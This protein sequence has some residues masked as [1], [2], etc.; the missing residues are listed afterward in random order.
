MNVGQVAAAAGISVRTLHHWDAVGLLT[1]GDRTS[2]GYRSY[3]EADLQRLQQV[4]T[5]R[6]LGFALD[7]VRVLLDDPA[8]DVLDHLRRQQELLA[9]RI[10][11][12]QTVAA[13]VHRA[14][15]ANRMGI[16]LDPQE[17]REVF[18]A[19]DPTLHAE[20]SEQRWGGTDAY[21]QSKAHT[22]SQSKQDWLRVK[23]EGEDVERRFADAMLAGRPADDP[24]VTALAEEH[25]QQISRNYYEC[26][27]SMHRALADLYVSD[28]RF[29]AHYDA[30]SPGLAQYLHDAVHAHAGG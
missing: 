8:V 16:N 21:A 14:V 11:R 15:E 3:G 22:W 20:Q 1:P 2:A 6:E 28:E 5:Y 26:D 4:L 30:V 29:V 27:E 25:R 18:G 12:M 23:A 24:S 7:E 17:L 19:H 13:M 9:D 10:A